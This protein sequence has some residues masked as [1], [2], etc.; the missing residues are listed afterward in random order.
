M[1]PHPRHDSTPIAG[2]NVRFRRRS[3]VGPQAGATASHTYT[4][5]GT[6]TVM[7]TVTDTVPTSSTATA[8]VVVRDDPPIAR[9][10]VTPTSGA[11]DLAVTVNASAS[12]DTD[13]TPIA[14]YT[15]DFGDGSVVGPQTG[16]GANHTYT[17]VGIYARPSGSRTRLQKLAATGASREDNP[18][19]AVSSLP[20]DCAIPLT[21]LL[22]D[23]A[24]DECDP[25]ASYTRLKD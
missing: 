14:S 3:D 24:T 22:L 5:E 7:V 19:V 9:L 6:F 2:Y 8:G 23:G 20:K 18:P 11:I 17:A 13:S 4:F 10:S 1:R 15:F 25:I 12:T 21:H 16:A